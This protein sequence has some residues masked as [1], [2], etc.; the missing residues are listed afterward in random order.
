ME[1]V[2]D[3]RRRGERRRDGDEEEKVGRP[4]RR[5]RVGST[6]LGEGTMTEG[7]SRECLE[8]GKS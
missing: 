4:R 6:G 8:N 5:T 1:R 2:R 3:K 7:C